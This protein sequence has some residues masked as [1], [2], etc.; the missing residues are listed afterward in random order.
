MLR[1]WE[2]ILE[3]VRIVDEDPES[4]WETHDATLVKNKRHL[5]EAHFDALRYVSENG[6]N[7]TVGLPAVMF[8]RVVLPR[9]RMA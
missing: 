4:A 1:L 6:T 5:N 9:R 8:G 7:F 2:A 3:T